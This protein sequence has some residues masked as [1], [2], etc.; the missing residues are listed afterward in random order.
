MRRV[1][2]IYLMLVRWCMQRYT[3]EQQISQPASS[4]PALALMLVILLL[5]DE[6][7]TVRERLNVRVRAR[8]FMCEEKWHTQLC[9]H[10]CMYIH[11]YTYFWVCSSVSVSIAYKYD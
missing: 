5:L 11:F 2:D 9:M 4:R 6:W 7:K 1:T 3:H 8:V 10:A